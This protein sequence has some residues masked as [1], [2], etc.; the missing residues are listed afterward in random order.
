[1]EFKYR[2]TTATIEQTDPWTVRVT[3]GAGNVIEIHITSDDSADGETGAILECDVIQTAQG[4][5]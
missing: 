5:L 3:T 2:D 1:M 4:S